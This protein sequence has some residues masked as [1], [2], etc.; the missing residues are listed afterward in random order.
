MRRSRW[1]ELHQCLAQ[2]ALLLHHLGLNDS[3]IVRLL[4]VTD[5]TIRKAIKWRSEP[6]QRDSE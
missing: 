2:R 4:G 1:L 3:A 6:L 5:K